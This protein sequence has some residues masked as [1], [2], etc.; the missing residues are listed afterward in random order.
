MA[1][2]ASVLPELRRT[3]V[4]PSRS[5]FR[6]RT[7]A[8]EFDTKPGWILGHGSRGSESLE[9][10][11]VPSSWNSSGSDPLDRCACPTYSTRTSLIV[12]GFFTAPR[13]SR[14]GVSHNVSPARRYAYDVNEPAVI[15][16]GFLDTMGRVTKLPADS[17]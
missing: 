14:C 11:A 8:C 17:S 4:P 10:D 12:A 16:A 15:A 7:S 5:L 1:S 9:S 3:I 13:E 6:C 2:A